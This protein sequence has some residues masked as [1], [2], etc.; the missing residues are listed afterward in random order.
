MTTRHHREEQRHAA[1]VLDTVDHARSLGELLT[2]TLRALDEHVGL[3]RSAFMLVLSD[4]AHPAGTAYAGVQ[5]GLRPYVMEEYFERWRHLDA[6]TSHAARAKF[7]RHGQA[8]IAGVYALLDAPHR[9][10]VDEFLRRS[11]NAQQLSFRLAGAGWS[12]GYLTLT[13]ASALDARAARVLKLV[14]PALTARLGR[15]LPRAIHGALSPRES[16]LAELLA[17]GF[18]NRRIGE[19]MCIE[20]DTVK[21]HV[22]H[23][24]AKLGVRGRTQL[25]LSWSSGQVLD[26]PATSAA[27]P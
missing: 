8:T 9:R 12:D 23:A 17:L 13:G 6:L 26:L 3:A 18:P 20:E 7:A 1:A 5:H 24:A 25:A 10:Y 21:K 22:A 14:V 19:I 2:V 27:R 11:G 4:G 16:Q 15:H